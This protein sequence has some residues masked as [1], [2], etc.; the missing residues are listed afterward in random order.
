M[1][2]FSIARKACD[3]PVTEAFINSDLLNH[4]FADAKDSSYSL[5][6]H[7]G[8]EILMLA[9]YNRKINQQRS[10]IL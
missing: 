8:L 2:E 1:T 7:D 3:F 4:V 5:T 10:N 9:F 6:H